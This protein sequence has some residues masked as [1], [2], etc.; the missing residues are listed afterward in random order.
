MN[1]YSIAFMCS[2]FATTT[3]CMDGVDDDSATHIIAWCNTPS[4]R[5]LSKTSQRFNFLSSDKNIIA[6]LT[7]NPNTITPGQKAYALLRA[8]YKSDYRAVEKLLMCGADRNAKNCLNLLPL[9]LARQKNDF[10]MIELLKKNNNNLECYKPLIPT[11]LLATYL[12]DIPTIQQ[13]M[14][15]KE[16]I[17]SY[18]NHNLYHTVLH[19][20]AII[21]NTNILAIVL[22]QSAI[23]NL[24][25]RRNAYGET[26]CYIA[27]TYGHAPFVEYLI[28][29]PNTN[30]NEKNNTMRSPLF[31]A[32]QNGHEAVVRLLTNHT[33]YIVNE[34]DEDDYTPLSIAVDN[35]HLNVVKIFF[36]DPRISPYDLYPHKHTTSPLGRA[37]FKGLTQMIRLLLTHL[38]TQEDMI[39]ANN[40]SPLHNAA[41][42]GH[43]DCVK[44]LCLAYP[45][46]INKRYNSFFTP[47]YVAVEKGYVDIVEHLL[48]YEET[49]AQLADEDGDT[50]LHMACIKNRPKCANLLIKHNPRLV[51]LCNLKGNSPLHT[52]AARGRSRIITLLV[53]VEGI[54]INKCNNNN[55]TPLDLVSKKNKN[56][57]NCLIKYGGLKSKKL[58]Q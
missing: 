6:I 11:S 56:I 48:S 50:P 35:G 36:T 18:P 34:Q 21:G 13:C 53:T 27:S 41:F 47:L 30:I 31:V 1:V 37:A 5:E 58:H 49:N 43:L 39:M 14:D 32:A 12:Q 24:I 23:H 40:E 2:F 22:K 15:Y 20:A 42:G 54:E 9:T 26:A 45:R 33:E 25:N 7:H 44:I 38:D 10:T 46:T 28:A 19:V 55:K 29:Q 3:L 52:A 4:K 8:T 17:S 57:I 51:L 16:Y